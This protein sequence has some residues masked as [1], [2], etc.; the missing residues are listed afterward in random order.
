MPGDEET[1]NLGGGESLSVCGG[2]NQRIA[3]HCMQYD[4]QS[5]YLLETFV[6]DKEVYQVCNSG[7]NDSSKI[8]YTAIGCIF[9]C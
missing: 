7:T 1:V 4:Y 6:L 5:T 2:A 8:N 9:I 3:P